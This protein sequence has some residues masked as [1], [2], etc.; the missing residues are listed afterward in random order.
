MESIKTTIPHHLIHTKITIKLNYIFKT[1]TGDLTE[2]VGVKYTI[3][4]SVRV[5]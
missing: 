1:A 3:V 5:I 4:F 2:L